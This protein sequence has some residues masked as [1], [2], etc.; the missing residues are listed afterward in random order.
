MEIMGIF[1]IFLIVGNAD[2]QGVSNLCQKFEFYDIY[3]TH[4]II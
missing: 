3:D 1:E 2:G 4:D